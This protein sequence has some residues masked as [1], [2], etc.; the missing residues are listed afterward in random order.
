MKARF[1][2][3]LIL[4]I[5][6][7]V[8]VSAT[9]SAGAWSDSST[10]MTINSGDSAGFSY[11][12]LGTN[13]PLQVKITL[14]DSSGNIVKTLLDT[15]TSNQYYS[16]SST[17]T[18]S[19][20]GGPG[21]YYLNFYSHDSYT[22]K[23]KS[24]TLTVNSPPTTPENPPSNPSNPPATNSPPSI[25]SISNQN[26]NEQSSYSYSVS[27]SDPD[28]DSL[29]Y[30]LSGPTWLSINSATGL[31]SGTTPSVSSDTNYAI[32][33]SVSDGRNS[34]VQASYTLTVKNTI[35]PD[36]TAPVITVISPADNYLQNSINAAFSFRI[37]DNVAIAGTSFY[38]NGVLEKTTSS[39]PN[40]IIYS[41][42]TSLSDGNY[43]WYL[44]ACD[45]SGNCASS[46]PRTLMI[47]STA[48][49]I[50]FVSPTPADNSV[51]GGTSIP[52]NVTASDS[53][54]GLK[55]V[56]AYL[57]NSSGSLVRTDYSN[58]PS[59]LFTSVGLSDGTYYLNATAY[60]NAG[61]SNNSGTRAI[62][63]DS[64]NPDITINYPSA[65]TY[66]SK[67]TELDFTVSEPH[68]QACWYSLDNGATKIS[69]S[70]SNGTNSITGISSSTGSNTWIVYANDTVGNFAQKAVTFSISSSSGSGS[71]STKYNY[72][73]SNVYNPP[74]YYEN[75]NQTSPQINLGS[76]KNQQFAI[77]SGLLWILVALLAILIIAIVIILLVRGRK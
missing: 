69:F 43:N 46:I 7:L 71:S 22:E 31:I 26:V 24:I 73:Y 3:G 38:L 65:K 37:S 1:L 35:V 77:T 56:T 68:L 12:F 34:P 20:Y 55:N 48:P 72:N 39:L 19:D 17:V 66:G 59:L 21:I 32:T 51:I 50:Q 53:G 74:A 70:C 28:G 75:I 63:L 2:F 14:L 44:Q 27:A 57:Y 9:S 40:N 6:L 41:Y 36:T 64:A 49:S 25:S 8:S 30:S 5:F 4:G 18:S 47:D 52:I 15:S 67:V 54:S 58:S 62:T 10:D 16:G 13:P 60:D 45:T 61:N 23:A 42:I 11:Y 33:V 29:T 76:P